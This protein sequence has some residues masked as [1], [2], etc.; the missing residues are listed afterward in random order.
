MTLLSLGSAS[1]WRN[2]RLLRLGMRVGFQVELQP[3][4]RILPRLE[5]LLLRLHMEHVA[6]NLPKKEEEDEEKANKTSARKHVNASSSNDT[7]PHHPAHTQLGVV[8]KK[9]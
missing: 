6:P 1:Q 7:D 9:S 3:L 5:E 4:L 2:Q 8:R